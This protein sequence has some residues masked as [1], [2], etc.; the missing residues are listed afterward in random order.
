MIRITDNGP[1]I[2]REDVSRIFNPFFTR[3]EGGTGLGLS[4]VW[5]IVERMGGK[6]EVESE[7]GKGAT[8]TLYFPLVKGLR[9]AE[10]KVSALT[11]TLVDLIVDD[12]G[13]DYPE[14]K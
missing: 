8:F 1:G 11:P 3:R 6:I 7:L 9:L 14:E 4:I 12:E 5:R 10:T 2:A 13:A